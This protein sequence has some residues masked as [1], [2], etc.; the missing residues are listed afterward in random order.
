[1]S[2][3][4]PLAFPAEAGEIRRLTILF[5]DLV[6]STVLSTRV[7]P[8]I[9]RTLV[10]RY[11]AD[12]VRIVNQY[13]GYIASTRGDGLLA[14]F[15]HPKA[16]EDDARR[17]VLAGLAIVRQIRR[18]DEISQ[19]KWGVEVAVRVGVHRGHVYLDTTQDDVFGL[20]ANLAA[21][22]SG[23]AP[24]G[25]VVV[26]DT[27]EPLVRNNFELQVLPPAAVK[28]VEELIPHHRVLG[29]RLEPVKRTNRLL[30]GREQERA[31]VER[32]WA[33]TQT[34]HTA[35]PGLVFVGE[36]GI[37]KSRL[38]SLAA[39]LAE[40]SGAVVLELTGSAFHTGVGLHPVRTLLERHCGITRLTGQVERL[41]LLTAEVASRGMDSDT[42]ALLAPVMGVAPEAGYEAVEVEGAKLH[43]S[44]AVAVADY[45]L[46]CLGERPAL[47]MA[48][49]MHWFDPSTMEVLR[50]LL[51][52][53][54]GRRLVVITTRPQAAPPEGWPVEV[55]ELEPLTDEQSDTLITALN[56]GLTPD[57]RATVRR[58]C[59]GVPLY[60]EQVVTGLDGA[61]VPEMLYEPLFA[62]LRAS[63]NANA[64]PVAE[65]AG[66]IGRQ[67]DRGLLG[68][69]CGLSDAEVDDVIEQLE[70]ALVLE[71]CG[72]DGWRFR[73]EL[74]REVA[75]ELAPPS[76]RRGL[77]ARVADALVDAEGDPD[78]RVVAGHYERADRFEDAADAY[79]E[80][81]AAARRRGALTEARSH[82]TAALS[83]LD[84]AA[85][86]P[87]RDRSEMSARMERGWLVTA[88]EGALSA[89][90]A[91]DFARCRELTETQPLD[92]TMIETRLDL[93]EYYVVQADL[94]G[95][96]QLLDSLRPHLGPERPWSELMVDIWSGIVGWLRGAFDSALVQLEDATDR[97]T[98]AIRPEVE[99]YNLYELVV[100][101]YSY[102]ASTR[103]VRGDF[104][105]TETALIKGEDL[106][107]GLGFP[108]GEFSLAYVRFVEIWLRVETGDLDSAAVLA[109]DLTEAAKGRGI[110]I[111]R[112]YGDIWQATI[113]ALAALRGDNLD[114]GALT[115][116]LTTVTGLLDALRKVEQ[117][118]YVIYFG[119]VTARL[120]IAAGQLAQARATLNAILRQTG[121]TE[122]RFYDAELL[123]LRSQT[124]ADS[125]SRLADIS[126]ALEL[127][128]GQGATL[129]E[130]RSALED[131]ELRGQ[132]A[133][134]GVVAAV[135]RFPADTG[136]SELQGARALMA[137]SDE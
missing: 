44:I 41:A 85:P 39:E 18:I 80:A 50:G 66:I 8:E 131:F 106:T 98:A 123:R 3:E 113:G 83:Q 115:A 52:P 37:G 105:G 1:M 48:E 112:N 34:A 101:A 32:A 114:P 68:T 55:V 92:D 89:A 45:L 47:L 130:L 135:S 95:T 84:R 88:E 36:S 78:W 133:Y 15:G 33:Q 12:V 59:D 25:S 49:D 30:V 107:R 7:E 21:R 132:P 11:R 57:E 20:G 110:D 4:D 23:L 118:E 77:H 72:V 103:L 19:R 5:A 69:V 74:L 94:R 104:A 54:G 96:L 136:W 70:N 128:R 64:M 109:A 108:E 35:T 16:H 73:H 117:S 62:R 51:G 86:G 28:G 67:V 17:A 58:R 31:R 99:V 129:F 42:V 22:V 26:S 27:V 40:Q 75:V 120:S 71:R 13:E 24:P 9:Y 126:A 102:L 127:A 122:M 97:F 6:D 111:L 119:G 29:E 60:L 14:L 93:A 76:V 56:P 124:H 10:G 61:G 81:T 125:A 79:Q 53:A 38:A 100:T 116:H 46:S 90:A 87:D 91:A 121:D 65:A 82:L 134:A 2:L 63:A 137:I 43:D